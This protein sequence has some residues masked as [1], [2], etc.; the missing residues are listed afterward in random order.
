M[1]RYE[2]IAGYAITHYHAIQHGDE[3][4][5]LLAWLDDAVRTPGRSPRVLEVGSDAGGTLFAWRFLWPEAEVIAVSL[6][7]GPYATSWPTDPHGATWVQG[8]SHDPETVAKVQAEL[9]GE[10]V[11]FLFIDGDHSYGGALADVLDYGPLVRPGGI[12][13]LHDVAEH[14]YENPPCEV[15]QVWEKLAELREWAGHRTFCTDQHPE[16]E[17]GNPV[18]WG[19][20]GAVRRRSPAHI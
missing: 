5:G 13:A 14:T 15:H 20:I 18:V 2:L 10:L 7:E 4:A 3:L 12:M 11:D 19:G 17:A 9:G 1:N 16:D 8:D 6:Q